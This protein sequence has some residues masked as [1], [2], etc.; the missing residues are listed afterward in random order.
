MGFGWDSWEYLGRGALKAET[1]KCPSVSLYGPSTGGVEIYCRV[2]GMAL[3]FKF[4][5]WNLVSRILGCA[6]CRFRK[7]ETNSTI[8]SLS[9][10]VEVRLGTST[11]YQYTST[12]IPVL[13]IP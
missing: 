2:L 13:S 7:S 8:G 5:F 12:G 3:G 11:T 6:S 1:M 9:T 10:V 4:I